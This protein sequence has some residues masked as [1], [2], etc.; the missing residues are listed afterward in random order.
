MKR[1]LLFKMLMVL[2]LSGV[3]AADS[4]RSSEA[5]H[6]TGQSKVVKGRSKKAAP[7]K[8]KE[9]AKQEKRAASDSEE[10]LKDDIIM[11]HPF[12]MRSM[13]RNEI[14]IVMNN[15]QDF[16]YY[17]KQNVVDLEAATTR[18]EKL[19]I[20]EK[21]RKS[22]ACLM[23]R[24]RHNLKKLREDFNSMLGFLF[25]KLDSKEPEDKLFVLSA[26]HVFGKINS[27][28]RVLNAYSFL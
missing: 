2:M 26:Q 3:E 1:L 7:Q 13:E 6:E 28:K 10:S 20:L 18:A 21:I 11:E 15:L 12:D 23:Q 25:S 16:F 5:S 4:I 8:K 14:E 17:N 9:Q 19:I 27:F 24:Y 22:D